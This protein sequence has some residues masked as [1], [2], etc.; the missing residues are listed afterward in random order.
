MRLLTLTLRGEHLSDPSVIY[1]KATRVKVTT[2]EKVHIN[3]D[4][5]YGGDAPVEFRNLK[6]HIEVFAS[7]DRIYD[8]SDSELDY[9]MEDER[10]F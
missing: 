5:E 9:D 7:S 2:D 8:D 6:A 1:K 4:G 10:D 3:L